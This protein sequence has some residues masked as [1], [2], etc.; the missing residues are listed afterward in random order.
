M[1]RVDEVRDHPN[2]LGLASRFQSLESP[3]DLVPHVVG[4][5]LGEHGDRIGASIAL[6][7]EPL[8]G[9][10]SPFAGEQSEFNRDIREHILDVEHQR[11]PPS[12]AHNSARRTE[13][14]RW[15]H[16]KHSV[17]MDRSGESDCRG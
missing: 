6:A 16:R 2:L 12:H 10:N 3:G 14:E 17:G 1:G 15:G 4:E 7:L 13:R 11:H 8:R 5:V 9:A